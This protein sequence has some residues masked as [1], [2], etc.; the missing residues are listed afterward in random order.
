MNLNYLS[1]G[2]HSRFII[3]VISIVNNSVNLH[4]ESRLKTA[5]CPKCSRKSSTVHSFYRRKIKDLPAFGYEVILNLLCKK[6]FC[7]N[8]DCDRS[9]FT[10]RFNDQFKPYS[11]PSII[12]RGCSSENF[13]CGVARE[14]PQILCVILC[15]NYVSIIVVEC[16]KTYE[17]LTSIN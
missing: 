12:V 7:K 10:E 13:G 15:V 4:V 8:D 2:S 16:V 5:K 14:V 1:I 17:L 6:F 3:K 9:I 11:R